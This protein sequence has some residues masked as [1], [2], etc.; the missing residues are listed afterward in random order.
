MAQ[1][2][3]LDFFIEKIV[4]LKIGVLFYEL[5]RQDLQDAYKIA[6]EMHKTECISFAE[7]WEIRCNECNM[8]SKEQL[9]DETF[10]K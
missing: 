4:N 8:D 3:S 2:T 1:Q 10:N 9:Y 7:E 5:Q 6:E